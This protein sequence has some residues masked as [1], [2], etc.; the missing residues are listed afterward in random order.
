MSWKKRLKAAGCMTGMG[1]LRLF[2]HW[3]LEWVSQKRSE[4]AKWQQLASEDKK[5]HTDKDFN[6]SS[7]GTPGAKRRAYGFDMAQRTSFFQMI[8]EELRMAV[9]ELGW[10]LELRGLPATASCWRA[11][12]QQIL[13]QRRFNQGQQTR[14]SGQVGP[15]HHSEESCCPLKTHF[16]GT[17]SENTPT[18][19]P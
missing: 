8:F 3:H 1:L 16:F 9:R 15:C 4:V 14:S 19:V 7:Q 6:E 12:E 11:C 13:C 10:A 17:F 5:L 2:L 18:N